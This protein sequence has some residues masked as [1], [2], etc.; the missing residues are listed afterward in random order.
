MNATARKIS[1][2]ATDAPTSPTRPPAVQLAPKASQADRRFATAMAIAEA[3]TL[4]AEAAAVL[5]DFEQESDD[6]LQDFFA[7]L[8][9]G[10]LWHAPVDGPVLPWMRGVVREIG[11]RRRA[12]RERDWDADDDG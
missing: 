3:P 7:Y 11:R 9:E 5:G 2:I 10:R 4:L 1:N 8:L 12:E 6:V